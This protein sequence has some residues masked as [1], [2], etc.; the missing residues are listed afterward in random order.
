M[1]VVSKLH[2]RLTVLDGARMPNAAEAIKKPVSRSAK[3]NA[4][5]KEKKQSETT[6]TDTVT[7]AV[8]SLR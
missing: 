5:R 2:V 4:K 1:T 6:D 7:E 8:S 3:K